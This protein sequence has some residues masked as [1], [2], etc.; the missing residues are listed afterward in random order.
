VILVISVLTLVILTILSIAYVSAIFYN[1]SNITSNNTINFAK[2]EL[3]STN[4]F[5]TGYHYGK[6]DAVV[7]IRD[8]PGSCGFEQGVKNTTSCV[9]GYNKAFDIYCK[10]NKYGCSE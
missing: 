7:G 9:T 8:P 2:I 1:S 5:L 10:T 3:N 6:K 4:D